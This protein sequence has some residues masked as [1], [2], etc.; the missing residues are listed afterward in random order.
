MNKCRKAEQQAKQ[1]K[2]KE[3]NMELE[4]LRTLGYDETKLA[5]WQRQIIL[6]KGEVAKKWTGSFR[7]RLRPHTLSPK[8]LP[9]SSSSPHCPA[10][11]EEERFSPKLCC[12]S[13]A[14]LIQTVAAAN[15]SERSST[16]SLNFQ[17][18]GVLVKYFWRALS[19]YGSVCSKRARLKNHVYLLCRKS[20]EDVSCRTPVWWSCDR[21]TK[22]FMWASGCSKC[23]FVNVTLSE[24]LFHPEHFRLLSLT[25]FLKHFLDHFQ[26]FCQIPAKNVIVFHRSGSMVNILFLNHSNVI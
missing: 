24:G 22:G 25:A 7:H 5:P 23:H 26:S 3:E 10:D 17:T 20:L 16:F 2:E 9:P 12:V 13:T 18:L 1:A 21:F 4:R 11:D 8:H 19:Y 15:A 14:R 6:K